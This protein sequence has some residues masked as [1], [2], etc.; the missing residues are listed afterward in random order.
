[1][2]AT[3]KKQDDNRANDDNNATLKENLDNR[4]AVDQPETTPEIVKAGHDQKVEATDATRTN[5]DELNGD[6]IVEKLTDNPVAR[7]NREA[8]KYGT[9]E[10]QNTRNAE[11][12]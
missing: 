5:M 12:K 9:V 3:N 11:S 1:M 6:N 2:M 10:D 4:P 7:S 8:A